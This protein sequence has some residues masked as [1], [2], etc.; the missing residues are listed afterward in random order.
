[1]FEKN[2]REAGQIVYTLHSR[3]LRKL[4]QEDLEFEAT[5]IVLNK[6]QEMLKMKIE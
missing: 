2:R 6:K 4:K 5:W 1:M 3:I